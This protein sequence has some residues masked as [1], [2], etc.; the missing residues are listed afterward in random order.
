MRN[1]IFNR[2]NMKNTFFINVVLL[3]SMLTI[4]TGCEK[5][6]E[7]ENFP[8]VLTTNAAQDIY[9]QGATLSGSIKVG[10]NIIVEECGILISNY[11]SMAEPTEY[12]A[13]VADDGTFSVK[14]SG[15][16]DGATYFYCSYAKSGAKYGAGALYAKGDVKSFTTAP[17]AN[18]VL[19]NTVV[20]S[21]SYTGLDV[22]AEI[23]DDGG[24]DIVSALFYYKQTDGDIDA[25]KLI[26]TKDAIVLASISGT[27][28]AAKITGLQSGR[29]YAICP[30]AGKSHGDVVYA[31]TTQSTIA[32]VSTAVVDSTTRIASAEIL[33]EGT[34]GVKEVG[35]CY[36]TENKEPTISNK[37]VKAT[38]MSNQFS[39]MLTDIFV[40]QTYYVRAYA[41][42][43]NGT[44]RYSER[45]TELYI[46]DSG[47]DGPGDN[48]NPFPIIR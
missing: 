6:T 17:N 40:K 35:F 24:E 19:G 43:N 13:D 15:L 31:T 2:N 37:S 41:I 32:F 48:D 36:S 10:K 5:D 39:G 46:S 29:R 45:S 47:N 30:V 18:P 42:E 21:I 22:S 38:L 33:N 8:P 3:L 26:E 9:R 1:N 16:N 44:V 12:K 34:S 20:S 23:L 28:M 27:T 11:E 4:A 7:P 25:D 14:V